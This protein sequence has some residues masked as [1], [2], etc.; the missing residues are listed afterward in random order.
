MQYLLSEEEYKKLACNDT[1]KVVIQKNKLQSLCTLAA[2]HVP[3]DREFNEEDKSPWGCILASGD[4]HPGYC[5]N[6]PVDDFCPNGYKEYS[7]MC[8]KRK[9]EFKKE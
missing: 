2:I 9:Y 5:D 7:M 3:A 6:C 1:S 8:I 4:N